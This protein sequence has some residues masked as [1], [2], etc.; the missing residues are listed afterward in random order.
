MTSSNRRKDASVELAV[1]LR[2]KDSTFG[3]IAWGLPRPIPR[4]KRDDACPSQSTSGKKRHRLRERFH[5]R[6]EQLRQ[7]HRFLGS[8][9]PVVSRTP[10]NDADVTSSSRNS[11]RDSDFWWLVPKRSVRNRD[12]VFENKRDRKLTK[13]NKNKTQE[14]QQ[15]KTKQNNSNLFNGKTFFVIFVFGSPFF[16]VFFKY[17]VFCLFYFYFLFCFCFFCFYLRYRRSESVKSP[18]ML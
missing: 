6:S 2:T 15:N 12:I 9:L 16:F 17:F 4:G 18:V 1:L 3:E 7:R 11:K 13:Q 14:K 5:S 8:R 10:A